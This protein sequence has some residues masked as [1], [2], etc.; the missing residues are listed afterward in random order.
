ML[1]VWVMVTGWRIRVLISVVDRSRRICGLLVGRP[2][3]VWW[4]RVDSP[5]GPIVGD[6]SLAVR[7]VGITM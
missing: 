2:V 7:V 4:V 5:T 1:L 6:L 3:L